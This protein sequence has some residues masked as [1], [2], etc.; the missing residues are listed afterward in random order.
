MIGNNIKVSRKIEAF[1]FYNSR[2]NTTVNIPEGLKHIL[3][4]GQSRQGKSS[5]I[6]MMTGRDKTTGA[7][8]SPNVIGC[9]FST[10][11]WSNS[12]YC[13]WDTAGLN[14]QDEG[15]VSNKQSTKNLISFIRQARGFHAAIMVVSWNNVNSSTT[16]QNWD[17]FYDCFLDQRVPIIICITGRGIET[18]D[19]DQNWMDQQQ[20]IIRELG[21]ESKTGKGFK[22]VVYSKDLSEINNVTMRGIY[23]ELRLRS[24]GYI[25]TLLRYNTTDDYYNPLDEMDWM[26][27]FKK[28]W[29]TLMRF[30]RLDELMITV[31]NAF[32]ELLIKIGFNNEDAEEISKETYFDK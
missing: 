9:T 14:E 10:E 12:E 19:E 25:T 5:I 15:Y 16:K 11:P 31:R 24:I 30:L 29:N 28:M 17:L 32:K 21:F 8:V 20:N 13:F 27:V 2:T 1:S 3:V 7:D 6:N 22:C 4:F 26:D 18:S 23:Q